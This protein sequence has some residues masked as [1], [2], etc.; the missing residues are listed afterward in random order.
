MSAIQKKCPECGEEFLII[1]QE[2]GFYKEKGLPH[3]GECPLC[4]Q[5]RRLSLRSGRKLYGSKCDKCGKEIIIAFEPPKDQKVYC[6]ECYLKFYE[7][8]DPTTTH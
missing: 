7:S 2:Q 8:F 4:R 6:R 5:K 3:P 1:D